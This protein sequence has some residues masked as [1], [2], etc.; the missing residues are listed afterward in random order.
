MPTVPPSPI[1]SSTD[2][3][4]DWPR[5]LVRG[6]L[7]ALYE[8]PFR[9]WVPGEVRRLLVEAFHTDVPAT[10]FHH[11]FEVEL[12]LG[13]QWAGRSWVDELL[14]HLDQLR[15]HSAPAPYWTQRRSGTSDQPA[16]TP[17][18]AP[19]RFTDLVSGLRAIGYLDRDF[20]SPCARQD[21]DQH[22][23]R[24]L[25]LELSRRLR[26]PGPGKTWP[27]QPDTWDTDTFYTLIEIFHD[28]VTRPRASWD[29]A[30]EF[31]GPHFHEFDTDAGRR[32]YRALVNRLLERHGID[33][34]LAGDGEDEGRLV[35]PVDDARNDLLTRARQ[36]PDPTVVGAV[37]H[38]IA[39]F[40]ARGAT[41]HDKRSA[42]AALA[43]VLEKRRDLL[44]SS[45]LRADEGA[46]FQIANQFDLRHS[47][48]Q[49]HVDYDPAFLDWVFWWYL[50]TVELTD[51][52]LARQDTGPA[53]AGS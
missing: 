30:E 12:H 46:L 17:A 6:E 23:G 9:G 5:E 33:L 27:L 14:A 11:T 53:A 35:R 10:E 52:I 22:L 16:P 50:A 42:I 18:Q 44:K 24:D 43:R 7:L 36:N 20:S 29:C 19:H 8:H 51:R 26:P 39:L 21:P 4:L 49:Q 48:D 15:E 47:N 40:R 25:D 38:G 1:W 45:L 32:V 37:D 2:Y 41:E 13:E 34:R 31:C 3:A 28:L